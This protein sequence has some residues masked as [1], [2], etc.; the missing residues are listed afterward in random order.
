MSC[1]PFQ[2][3]LVISE[4]FSAG[5][6]NMELFGILLVSPVWGSI[7]PRLFFRCWLAFLGSCL[8]LYYLCARRR[9]N[10]TAYLAVAINQITEA[11]FTALILLVVFYLLYVHYPFGRNNSEVF[12]FWVFSSIQLVHILPR[13]SSRIDLLLEKVQTPVL[14]NESR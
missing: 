3:M 1:R 9:V 14:K 13:I 2:G 6:L 7:S 11:V 4:S 5:L 12:V 10:F 8:L